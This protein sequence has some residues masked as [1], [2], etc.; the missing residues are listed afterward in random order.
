MKKRIGN[1]IKRILKAKKWTYKVLSEKSN[2]SSSTLSNISSG[3]ALPRVE[4][5]YR[6]AQALDTSM[7]YLINNE[8][9]QYTIII[10][11]EFFGIYSQLNATEKNFLKE[12]A[13]RA[14]SFK[15]DDA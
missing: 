12:C 14:H 11:K 9:D 4:T 2:V 13:K 1:N 5:L 8:S 15:Q 6:I 10:D 7:D 3:K